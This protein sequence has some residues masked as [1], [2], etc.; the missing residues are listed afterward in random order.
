VVSDELIR[1]LQ[2]AGT[3]I[4]K[5]GGNYGTYAP[6]E[7]YLLEAAQEIETLRAENKDLHEQ[8]AALESKEVCNVAHDDKALEGCPYCKLTERDKKYKRLAGA[9][10]YNEG[11]KTIDVAKVLAEKNAQIADLEHRI[12]K[13]SE[14]L[15]GNG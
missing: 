1:K 11:D 5:W 9:L 14:E 13:L 15:Q 10:R 8:V 4:K 3:S 7:K 6:L 2:E 12:F